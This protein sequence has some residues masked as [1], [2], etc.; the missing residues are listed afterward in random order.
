VRIEFRE[1][2]REANTPALVPNN[3]KSISPW[4]PRTN[5]IRTM[6]RVEQVKILVVL[7]R[8]R[9]VKIT[10]KTKERHLATLSINR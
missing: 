8:I 9:Y 3:E 2:E 6:E 10:L 1:T 4:T 7:P 5:P